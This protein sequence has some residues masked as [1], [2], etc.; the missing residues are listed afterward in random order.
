MT[1]LAAIALVGISAPGLNCLDISG[2]QNGR[3]IR[4]LR[5]TRIVRIKPVLD[6]GVGCGRSRLKE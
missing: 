2:I 6:A 4:I 5:M 3:F 1:Y